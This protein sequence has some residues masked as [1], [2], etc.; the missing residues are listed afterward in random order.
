MSPQAWLYKYTAMIDDTAELID[1]A[2]AQLQALQGVL[3]EDFHL[4]RRTGL[5]SVAAIP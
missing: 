2:I 3:A 5:A 1:T 4:C